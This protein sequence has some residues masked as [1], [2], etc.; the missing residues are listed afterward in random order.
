MMIEKLREATRVLHEQVEEE[1]LAGF[2]MDHT[3][4]PEQYKLLI[5]QNYVAY[6]ETETKIKQ[7]LPDYPANKHVLLQQDMELLN[8]DVDL[9][10]GDDISFQCQNTAEA[11]GAAYVVE[12]SAL[13]GMVIAKNLKQ[14]GKLQEIDQFYFFNGNRDGLTYWK[15]FKKELETTQLSVEEE[16]Q[17]IE[18]AKETFLFFQKIFRLRPQEVL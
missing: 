5:Y 4:T 15:Q 2:I 11:L 10:T 17:A 1:N 7:F 12:G 8:L 9:S 16:N 3:I 18:K 6:K 13:G 14:C